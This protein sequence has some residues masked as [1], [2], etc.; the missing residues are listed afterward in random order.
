MINNLTN[1]FLAVALIIWQV[2]EVVAF[3]DW[4]KYLSPPV[5]FLIAIWWQTLTLKKREKEKG[6]I[7]QALLDEKDKTIAVLK[8]IID[9]KS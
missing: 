2:P 3:S 5:C 9:G 1:S 7:T 4:V 8:K 6:E